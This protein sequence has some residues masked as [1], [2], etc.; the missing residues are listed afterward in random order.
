MAVKC[1]FASAADFFC[2]AKRLFSHKVKL[3]NEWVGSTLNV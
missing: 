3:G 1:D 2:F